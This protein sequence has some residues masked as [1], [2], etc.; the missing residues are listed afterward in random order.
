[1]TK[2]TVEINT[3]NLEKA[4]RLFPKELKM[5]LGDGFDHI[6]RKFLKIFKQTRLQGPP[7]VKARPHGIFTHFTRASLVSRDIEGMGMTIFSDSKISRMHEEGATIKSAG[8]ERLAAPLSARPE[9]FIGGQYPGRLKKRYRDPRAMK[10]VIRIILK[11]KQFLVKVKRRSR[12]LLPLFV[13][14]NQIRIRPRLGF[15]KTWDDMQ[16]E[17]IIILN[18]SVKKAIDSV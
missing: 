12:E 5:Q 14:K 9:M 6:S 15:Y 8:G 1:M 18:K 4:I 10:N 7:G 13:L 3:K 11:G 2:L 16:N 17:R